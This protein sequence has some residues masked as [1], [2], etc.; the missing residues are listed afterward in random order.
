MN[1][2]SMLKVDEIVFQRGES[3]VLIPREVVLETMEGQPTVTIV[4]ITRGK[5]QE[6]HAMATSNDPKENVKSDNEVVKHGLVEPKL[7]EEQIK[8]IKPKY[9]NAI[10]IA[11]MSL[12]LGIEQKEVAN[13]AKE[14]IDEQED[15]L[16]KKLEKKI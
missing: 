13:K 15:E 8:D 9:A 11:I 6:I 14:I 7:T 12:S 1:D 4:P 2:M 10:A 5:L 16:K 3:G